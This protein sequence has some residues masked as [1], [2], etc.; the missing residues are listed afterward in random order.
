MATG[1]DISGD[2]I[3]QVILPLLQKELPNDYERLAVAIIGTGS[4]VLGLDD[5]ISRD[6]HWGPR[7]NIMY[8][9]EDQEALGPKVMGL[10]EQ[11]VPSSFQ[12]FDVHVDVGN[13]TGVCCSAVEDLFERF[14]GTQKLPETDL[15]WLQLCEVD[16]LHVTSG[17]VVY[18]GAGELTRRREHLAYYPENVW[19]KRIADW[20]MYV[21]GRDAPYNIHRIAKRDD[22][23]TST[24]YLGQCLKRVMELCF[25]L[26]KQYGPYTKWLNRTFRRLPCFV[27]RIVPLFDRVLVEQNWRARVMT[28]VD[29]NFVIAEALGE[30]KLTEPP[31][32]R[33][34]EEGL[35]DL[36]LYDSAGQIYRSLP[37]DLFAPSFN[38]IELWEKMA[39]ECLF[40]SKDYF[41]KK[42]AKQA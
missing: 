3:G 12:E 10:I 34:F 40:D 4:D 28:L 32:R 16:L 27:D 42:Y 8:L 5:S 17:Q 11:K 35:T 37:P 36:T 2:F 18:D 38:Q 22:E 7:A 6:H 26:N 9:R 14:L 1:V 39:R 20:C 13:Q 24:I 29:I 33:P 30:L 15:D 23:L 19:K 21:T 31:Q 25:A 41:K